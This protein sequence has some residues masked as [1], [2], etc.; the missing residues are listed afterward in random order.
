VMSHI[1]GLA[2]EPPRRTKLPG[3][4]DEIAV[5]IVVASAEVLAQFTVDPD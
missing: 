4:A 2:I 5:L 3:E 1:F